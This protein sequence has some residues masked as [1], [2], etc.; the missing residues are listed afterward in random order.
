MTF[1]LFHT[2]FND[3]RGNSLVAIV[4][5]ESHMIEGPMPTIM[6]T[7]GRSHYL[8]IYPSH[9][10]TMGIRLKYGIA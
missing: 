3:L 1:Q 7:Q 2:A 5:Q 6:T 9:R 10:T 8:T 4:A